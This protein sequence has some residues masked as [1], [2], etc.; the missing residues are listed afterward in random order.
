MQLNSDVMA[1]HDRLHGTYVLYAPPK[2]LMLKTSVCPYQLVCGPVSQ[3]QMPD[4]QSRTQEI[5]PNIYHTFEHSAW[6]HRYT[7]SAPAAQ[8][9]FTALL[10]RKDTFIPSGSFHTHDFFSRMGKD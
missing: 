1:P 5:T 9:Y 2:A 4:S 8:P 6:W 3:V 10:Y 7:A